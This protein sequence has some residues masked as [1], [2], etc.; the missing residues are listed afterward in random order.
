[1]LGGLWFVGA[2]GS[3]AGFLLPSCTCAHP[4]DWLTSSA[5]KAQLILPGS[6]LVAW[7]RSVPNVALRLGNGLIAAVDGGHKT[8]TNM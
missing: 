5:E 1:M 2:F 6:C 8:K 7:W 3:C 4:N